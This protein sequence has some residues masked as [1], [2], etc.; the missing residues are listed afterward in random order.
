MPSLFLLVFNPHCSN[1]LL[2]STRLSRFFLRITAWRYQCISHCCTL[3]VFCSRQEIGAAARGACQQL[4]SQ[5][6]QAIADATV[7]YTVADTGNYSTQNFGLNL[8]FYEYRLTCST[9]QC[10]LDKVHL[11]IVKFLCRYNFRYCLVLIIQHKLFEFAANVWHQIDQF[12]LDNEQSEVERCRQH[13]IL[14]RLAYGCLFA[15][16]GNFRLS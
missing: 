10:L 9:L 12:T 5:R 14:Q 13:L 2:F 15:L 11:R 3:T 16:R 8:R 4:L 7:D 6:V 1:H